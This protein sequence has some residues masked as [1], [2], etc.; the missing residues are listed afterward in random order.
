M[1]LTK[2]ET[3]EI[4]FQCVAKIAHERNF[5]RLLDLIAEMGARL[6]VCDRCS[7]WL[8]DRQTGELWTK[9]AQGVD[10]LRM[11]YGRG[12]VGE[13]VESGNITVIN[14]PY[15]D[16]RFNRKIDVAT[17]YKTNSILVI[18]MLGINGTVI[19]AFQAINKF[20]DEGFTSNDV[21]HLQLA[22]TFSAKILDAEDLLHTASSMR[23]EQQSAAKK[24]RS[25]IFNEFKN[26][27][28]LEI[29]TFS[30]G[31]DILSGD[32]YALYKTSDG[33]ALI[34]CVDGMGHGI[35][36][37]LTSFSVAATIKQ[38]IH[39]SNTLTELSLELLE[40]LH[41][42]LGEEEQISCAFFWLSPD[43]KWIDYFVA[44]FYPPLVQDGDDVIEIPSNNPPI[45]NFTQN[46]A[47]GRLAL[48]AFSKLLIY[49]DGLVEDT[50]FEFR[51]NQVP[52][53]LEPAV[54]HHICE[55]IKSGQMD[56]DVTIVYFAVK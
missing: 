36:P 32:T 11:P 16:P 5:D 17:G 35:L 45:M 14:S 55:E 44:G 30:Q 31:L 26:D 2:D 12:I 20:G 49:T 10:R 6:I 38:F 42:V 7:I 22:V 37:S 48:T 23:A 18:P 4:I 3:L 1:E 46:I 33:G 9:V 56:D 15:D 52:T 54:L 19:G 13:A 43:R 34:Y 24:Q 51:R 47:V 25:I 53:L 39:K 8:I 27:K 50:M 40:N 41:A 28:A 29:I 21:K